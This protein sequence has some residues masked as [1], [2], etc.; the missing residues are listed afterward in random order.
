MLS[1]GATRHIALKHLPTGFMQAYSLENGTVFAFTSVVNDILQHGIPRFANFRDSA[2]ERLSIVLWGQHACGH[3]G[4]GP[5]RGA[6][7]RQPVPADIDFLQ[8]RIRDYT[9]IKGELEQCRHV[10]QECQKTKKA[11]SQMRFEELTVMCSDRGLVQP[12][13]S[14]KA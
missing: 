3:N 12:E 6:Y 5:S 2:G 4:A 11:L 10:R 14:W 1:L 7:V 9:K 8:R 13:R